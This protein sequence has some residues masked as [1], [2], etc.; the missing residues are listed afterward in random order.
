M[1][2]TMI[3]SKSDMVTFDKI[4]SLTHPFDPLYILDSSFTYNIFTNCSKFPLLTYVA[5]DNVMLAQ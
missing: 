3:F 2:S 5:A 4:K 1:I